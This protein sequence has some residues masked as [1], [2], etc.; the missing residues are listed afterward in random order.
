MSSGFDAPNGYDPPN[1]FGASNGTRNGPRHWK[2]VP[3]NVVTKKNIVN[4]PRANV[5]G[6]MR[7]LPSL[8]LTS[9]V[10]IIVGGLM[11]SA[12]M[13]AYANTKVPTAADNLVN[14]KSST[15]Y[16]S[17]GT[18][19]MAKFSSSDGDVEILDINNIPSMMQNAI[20]AAEDKNFYTNSGVDPIGIARAAWKILNGASTQS[21]STITQQYVK[22]SLIKDSS[23][24]LSR[25]IKEIFISVK[26]TQG[27]GTEKKKQILSDYLNSV[28]YGRGAY[29]V[30][31]ASKA[32]FGKTVDKLNISQ[33]AYLAASVNRPIWYD[34]REYPQYKP[35][36]QSHWQAVI[37]RMKEDG[38]I[39]QSDVDSAEFPSIIK[40]KTTVDASNP[41]SMYLAAMVKTELLDNGFTEQDLETGGYK[42]TTTFSK[43]AIAN[44]VKS[45]RET[46][47]AHKTWPKGT[48]AGLVSIDNAT[49]AV[50]A[51]YAGEGTKTYS[52]V[53][54]EG[55]QPGSTF[56]IPTLVANL[57]GTD[58]VKPISL[59]SRFKA[60]YKIKVSGWTVRNFDS[61]ENYGYT[62]LIKATALSLNT[63][64][65]QL[66]KRVTPQG[67]IDA[68]QNLGVEITAKNKCGNA[69]ISN[70]LGT[71][72]PHVIDMAQAY[73]TIANEGIRRDWYVVQ[74]VKTASGGTKYK[75][76]K[77][78]E[79][80][81]D[82]DV[83]YDTTYAM[84]AVV[85]SGTASSL[86][87]FDWPVAGK[88]GTTS[89][90]TAGWFVGFSKQTTTAVSIFRL[91]SSGGP[92]ALKGWGTYT[93]REVTGASF[94]VQ[95][96]KSYMTK[97]MNGKEAIAFHDPAYG[98]SD[99]H[100]A[101]TATATPTDTSTST[102]TS[103]STESASP[104]TTE[105]TSDPTTTD[106]TTDPTSG[107]TSN[108]TT[109]ATSTTKKTGAAG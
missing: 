82:A 40:R 49:G 63:V 81:Y 80:V 51:I 27:G 30:Q 101:P 36:A 28:Y 20:I 2:T 11:M 14:S 109:T 23:Q 89:G 96:W 87:S 37:N 35:Y 46:L 74:I 9:L 43:K 26:L 61:G 62:N 18:T 60:P 44:A 64:Y 3:S 103:T 24:T 92:I 76:K 25:K 42:I 57:A 39:Q 88:T 17:D 32:Y 97:A 41:Q 45:V 106:P 100:A 55:V 68:A 107:T 10:I 4:Y 85:K 71:C 79:Q 58:D 21:G 52:N 12:I 47:G 108:P 91:N 33:L 95:L 13:V 38:Y 75:H 90:N 22:L 56:K 99:L 29:G 78:E 84:Q 8:R 98:G 83:M 65:A 104:T 93:G 48:Q 59:K 70:V 86:R 72:S 66:N 77:S 1:G 53:T 67:T 102:V 94:P 7:W 31:Q 19:V 105:P 6:W 73:S 15:I 50:R 16:Y 69:V 5:A 54:D 34:Y